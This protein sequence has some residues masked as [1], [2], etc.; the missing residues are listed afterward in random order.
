MLHKY[1]IVN[2]GYPTMRCSN[3]CMDLALEGL[4]MTQVESKHVAFRM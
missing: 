2:V 1:F 3:Y 4:K